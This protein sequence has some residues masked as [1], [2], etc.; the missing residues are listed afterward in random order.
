MTKKPVLPD[1][2]CRVEKSGNR[3]NAWSTDGTKYTS[4]I[5]IGCRKNAFKGD[6]LVGRFPSTS[7][8]KGFAWRKVSDEIL[9][10]MDGP[11]TSTGTTICADAPSRHYVRTAPI[12]FFEILKTA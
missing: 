7:G 9:S 12:S 8:K 6:Y 2:V 4:D 3:Y 1:V 5:T 10:H 11:K